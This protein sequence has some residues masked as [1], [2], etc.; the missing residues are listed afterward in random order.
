VLARA[1]VMHATPDM[2]LAYRYVAVPL[3]I[4]SG[5]SAFVWNLLRTVQAAARRRDAPPHAG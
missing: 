1:T 5:S 3:A 4:I 2:S